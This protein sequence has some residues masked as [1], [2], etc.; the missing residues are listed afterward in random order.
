M[1][2]L[3]IAA[4]QLTVHL[5]DNPSPL[6]PDRITVGN[7]TDV[8]IEVDCQAGGGGDTT[9]SFSNGTEVTSGLVAFGVTQGDGRLRI[10]PITHL[11][12][13][14]DGNITCSGGSESL[15]VHFELGM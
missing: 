9:W 10:Y 8:I 13:L 15:Q 14:E 6:N 12:E 2:S 5:P 7:A 1:L 4:A 3:E 11:E